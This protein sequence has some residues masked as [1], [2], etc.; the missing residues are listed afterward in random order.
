VTAAVA[1]Y[2]GLVAVASGAAFAVYGLDK[3]RAGTGGRR[4]PERT[5][6]LLG[7][8]GG[9]PGALAARRHY[10]HKTRKVPFRLVF[11]AVVVLHLA[12]VGAVAYAAAVLPA[13]ATRGTGVR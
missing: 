1:A 13:A 6:H 9:W 8:A 3:R 11:W 4:V 2:L 10:R 5:L 7:L 12:L